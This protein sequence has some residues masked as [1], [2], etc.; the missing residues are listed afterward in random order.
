MFEY[1]C[2]CWFISMYVD[3]W[4]SMGVL[5]FEYLCLCWFISMYVD[6]W[7]SMGVLIFEYLCVCVDFRISMC[8]LIFNICVCVLIFEYLCVCWF[9]NIYVCVDFWISMTHIQHTHRPDSH[10]IYII[11]MC[12]CLYVLSGCYSFHVG[13]QW[14][15][16]E[17]GE[18]GRWDEEERKER[19]GKG[20]EERKG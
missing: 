11:H 10:R 19:N 6:F 17:M 14:I 12:M 9:L 16:S 3:F 20:S 13:Y 5:I 15:E 18:K 1:L 7:T 8:V 4:I 2:A